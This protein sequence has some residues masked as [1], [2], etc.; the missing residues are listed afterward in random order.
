MPSIDIEK[1]N[2]EA[3]VELCAARYANLEFKL[4]KLEHRIDKLEE[5]LKEIRDTVSGNE[6]NQYKT[7]IAIGTAVTGALIAGIIT[8]LVH[9]VGK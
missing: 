4:S 8:L 9:I 7:L 6:Q 5:Y 3:H 2:L 1:E